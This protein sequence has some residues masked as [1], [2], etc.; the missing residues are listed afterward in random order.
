MFDRPAACASAAAYSSSAG[1]MSVA[2]T[3]PVGPTRRA[4]ASDCSPAPAA[5]SSTRQPGPT[6]AMSNIVSVAVPSHWPRN[7]PQRCHASAALCHCARVVTL[8]FCPSNHR[9]I[10]H[11]TPPRQGVRGS[12]R[13]RR[14]RGQSRIWTGPP[15]LA[16]LGFP[17]WITVSSARSRA[18]PRYSA[19]AGRRWWCASCCAAARASTTSIAACR[20]CRR[21][22]SRSACAGSRRSASCDACA[23]A[24][25]GSTS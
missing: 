16:P 8:N 7:G 10:V 1:A 12:V 6:A 2:S 17:A 24:G 14:Q 11:R 20:A 4:A 19:S 3:W 13:T 5:T 22:C 15:A 21:R 23:P 25:S 9:S 18:A